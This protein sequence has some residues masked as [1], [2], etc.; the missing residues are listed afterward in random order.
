MRKHDLVIVGAGLSGLR[1][2]LEGV[3]AG[4]DVA[5]ISKIHP[6]RSHSCAAQ[7]GVNAAI[8]PRDSRESHTFDT[9]KGAD[10]IGDEDAIQLMCHEAPE[11]ILELDRMGAPF[12]R[13]EDGSI[14]Q[15]P[16]GGANF[17]RTC[18]A[19]DRTGQVMLH[20][21]WEQLVKAQVKVYEEC[22]ILRLVTDKQGRAAGVV[23]YDIKTGEVF[24]VG[25][26]GIL[27]ASGGYGRV[28][29]SNTNATTNT[30]DG[31]ALALRA[32]AP[33]ADMEFVQFHPTGLLT[34]GVLV[35]EG[36]RG[37]GG[38]LINT[39]GERFM[40]KYAPKKWELASRD[41]VARAEQTEIIEGRGENGAIF[42]DLRHLGAEKILE[43]LPQIRQLALDLEG[44][45]PIYKPIPVRPT[46]HYSMGGIRTDKWGASPMLGLFSAGEA[47]CVSVHGA[48]RLG[49]NSLLDTVVF[50]KITGK[51]ASQFVKT[52]AQ[53]D[54]PMEAVE[55]VKARIQTLKRGKGM[56]APALHTRMS[57]AMN[58]HCGVFRTPEGMRQMVEMMPELRQEYAQISV[59]DQSSIFNIDLLRTME[60]GNML[61]LAECIAKGALA[62]EESR[63]AHFRTDLPNRDD[64][65]WR[66]HTLA[67]WDA[68]KGEV[69]LS[70]EPVRTL[71]LPEFEPTAR[72]Y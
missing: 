43:R 24:P 49:G 55:E 62:R 27:I 12:S 68:G 72:S 64:Q 70:Y 32:G 71:G 47:A 41:V 18:Y 42:L 67:S 52:E 29:H 51:H 2:A 37:E 26:K 63:G 53:P 48:N 57:Q 46:V 50:G 19:A 16:F 21:L 5:I 34:T 40:G 14:A 44:V 22:A 23:A 1:A 28:Y 36:A 4:I 10:Y 25:G 66:K 54:F 59:Q 61:D 33:L 30:G 45:D 3:R 13:L 39:L 69:V 38:Y 56:R 35:T 11:V 9:V 6:L 15:R 17:D 60:M 20:V 65:N 8:D 31:M 7:G 58:L